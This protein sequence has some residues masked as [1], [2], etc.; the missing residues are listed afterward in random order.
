M[1]R[2]AGRGGAGR[3]SF[4]L[5]LGCL[6]E[7]CRLGGRVRGE[8]G[9]G[10]GHC[11]GGIGWMWLSELVVG[12]GWDWCR[13]MDRGMRGGL[14]ALLLFVLGLGTV[15]EEMFVCSCWSEVVSLL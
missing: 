15:V 6:G 9:I 7:G 8:V 3:G 5:G 14:R 2:W 12:E 10:I 11:G 4:R 13:S 1:K